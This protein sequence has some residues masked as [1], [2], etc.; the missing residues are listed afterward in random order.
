MNNYVILSEGA[1]SDYDPKYF[2]GREPITQAELDMKGREIGDALHATKQEDQDSY[3]LREL[4]FE[5]M[6]AWLSTK[7]YEELPKEIPEINVY[8]D[9]PVSPANQ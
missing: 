5:K 6:R 4:W 8:Y 2:C 1:Y 7:G 3:D 9:I